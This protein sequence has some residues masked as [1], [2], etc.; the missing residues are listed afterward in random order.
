M[1]R[2]FDAFSLWYLHLPGP[3]Q[4]RKSKFH[5]TSK[6]SKVNFLQKAVMLLLELTAL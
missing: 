6:D 4:H 3:Y 2:T 5:S 1:V